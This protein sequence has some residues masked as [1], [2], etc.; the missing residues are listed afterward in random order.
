MKAFLV[1]YSETQNI[2][3][4]KDSKDSLNQRLNELLRENLLQ[5]SFLSEDQNDMWLHIIADDLEI[6]EMIVKSINSFSGL[7]KRIV[8]LQE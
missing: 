3:L 8:T 1:H 6:V 4:S 5:R 2:F 7:N